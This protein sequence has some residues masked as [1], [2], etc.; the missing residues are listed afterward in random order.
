MQLRPYSFLVGFLLGQD[1]IA[2]HF[3]LE[4]AAAQ[5]QKKYDDEAASDAY[6]VFH[7]QS[8]LCLIGYGS[9]LLYDKLIAAVNLSHI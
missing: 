8:L 6:S 4:V 2:D 7:L 9:V 1:P 3:R 5:Q